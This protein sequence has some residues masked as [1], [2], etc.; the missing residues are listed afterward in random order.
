M[1]ITF[2]SFERKESNVGD[3]SDTRSAATIV[4]NESNRQDVTES[5]PGACCSI[6]NT[7]MTVHNA[8]P[9]E[10]RSSRVMTVL[11]GLQESFQISGIGHD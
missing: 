8:A 6:G 5:K 2:A 11:R 4:S 10:R 3:P 9:T 1:E 7:E